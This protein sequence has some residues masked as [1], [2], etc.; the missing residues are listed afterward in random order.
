[1]TAVVNENRVMRA[2]LAWGRDQI[3]QEKPC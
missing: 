3:K 2:C 1:M